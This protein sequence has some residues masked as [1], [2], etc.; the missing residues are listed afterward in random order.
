MPF[1]QSVALFGFLEN[2]GEFSRH[3]GNRK[4]LLAEPPSRAVDR[5]AERSKDQQQ[6]DQTDD[7]HDNPQAQP[8]MI[9]DPGGDPHTDRAT[10]DPDD[11]PFQI[12]IGI[13][14]FADGIVIAGTKNHHDSK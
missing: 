13:S 8:K 12:V 6:E 11:L 10:D 4:S 14:P 9:V 7:R 3:H 5:N 2:L 1:H